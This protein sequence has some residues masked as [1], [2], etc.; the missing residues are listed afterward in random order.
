MYKFVILLFSICI[1]CSCNKTNSDNTHFHRKRDIY[2]S[3]RFPDDKESNNTQATKIFNKVHTLIPNKNLDEY[4]NFEVSS[5]FKK[6]EHQTWTVPSKANDDEESIFSLKP[7][8]TDS[9][10]KIQLKKR[11]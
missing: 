6:N 8:K 3:E 4:L 1:I 2:K 9:T 11:N 10:I 7:K 5:K